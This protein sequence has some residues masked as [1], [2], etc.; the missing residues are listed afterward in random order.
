MGIDQQL[1]HLA[2][3]LAISVDHRMVAN[4]LSR[5]GNREFGIAQSHQRSGLLN[6]SHNFCS[7]LKIREPVVQKLETF[8]AM[9]MCPLSLQEGGLEPSFGYQRDFSCNILAS[10]D[11]T[12][13]G[14]A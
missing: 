14:M 3:V 7:S 13:R 2:D 10:I 12:W 6:L 1:L 4:V 11:R 8:S 5:I 9:T